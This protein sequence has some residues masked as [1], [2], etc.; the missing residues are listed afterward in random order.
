MARE[1]IYNPG[2]WIKRALNRARSIT[3]KPVPSSVVHLGR[4]WFGGFSYANYHNYTIYFLE[5]LAQKSALTAD[6][7]MDAII[8]ATRLEGTCQELCRQRA[9]RERKAKAGAIWQ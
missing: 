8:A 7:E 4:D 2:R 1:V 6:D 3:P 9:R 5:Q